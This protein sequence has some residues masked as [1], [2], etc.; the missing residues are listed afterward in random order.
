MWNE[1]NG[2]FWKPKANVED[3]VKL[4]L[5]VGRAIRDAA[6]QEVYIGPAT[7]GIKFDFLE[8][9]FQAGLLD[10]WRAVSVH[11]YRQTDPRVLRV[12]CI[13]WSNSPS[14]ICPMVMTFLPCGI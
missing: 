14:I 13:S 6:P 9:C 11:P 10:Y 3:Y 2:S 4:A 5:A 7:S 12:F 8:A 1:P